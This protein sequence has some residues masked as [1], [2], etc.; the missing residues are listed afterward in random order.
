MMK[1]IDDTYMGYSRSKETE[2]YYGMQDP[3][4]R[5]YCED[6]RYSEAQ[7]VIIRYGIENDIDV[8]EYADPD[9][10]ANDMR[11]IWSRLRQDKCK[12]EC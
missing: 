8:S 9:I 10:P 12:K 2:R 7:L 6:P 1:D 4:M 3:A 5:S 11:E